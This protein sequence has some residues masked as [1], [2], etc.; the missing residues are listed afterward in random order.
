[1]A[2]MKWSGSSG[3]GSSARYGRING[4]VGNT[5]KYSGGLSSRKKKNY[6]TALG[7]RE[8]KSTEKEIS[9]L[10]KSTN[11]ILGK[12]EAIIVSNKRFKE[13]TKKPDKPKKS[14]KN[15]NITAQSEKAVNKN[16]NEK[17]RHE[18]TEEEKYEKAIT[19]LMERFGKQ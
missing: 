12:S 15:T 3:S 14:K 8:R 11:K 7:Y 18:L 13:V 17:K 16:S 4:D 1:M 6:T 9:E 5:G 19:R 2:R 10:I